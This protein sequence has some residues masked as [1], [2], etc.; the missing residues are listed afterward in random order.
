M[1]MCKIPLALIFYYVRPRPFAHLRLVVDASNWRQNLGE[2]V[3]LRL[4]CDSCAC[5]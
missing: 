1:P 3:Q 2:V 5:P 4:L